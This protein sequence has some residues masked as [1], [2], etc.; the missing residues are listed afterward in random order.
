MKKQFQE[1][2][3]NDEVDIYERLD[4]LEKAYYV[5]RRNK[6][7][8]DPPSVDDIAE[9]FYTDIDVFNLVRQENIND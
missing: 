4:K 6:L 5:L 2:H 8:P 1:K 7:V 9:Y 3:L